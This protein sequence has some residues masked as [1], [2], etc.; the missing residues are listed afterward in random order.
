MNI[1]FPFRFDTRGRT[2]EVDDER[3]IR[4]LIE[5]LLFTLPGERVNRPDLGSGL[6]QLVFSPNSPELAAATQFQVQGA[7]Q[8]WLG[9]LIH[10]EAVEV[11]SVEA[12]LTVTVR[13]ITRR[14][15]QT[16]TAHFQ[17]GIA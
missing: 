5:Q 11:I 4:D 6:M 9:D 1:A 10:V 2:A 15:Q 17:R 13:Y 16:Q 14:T 3:H 8:Q 12:T 7:L